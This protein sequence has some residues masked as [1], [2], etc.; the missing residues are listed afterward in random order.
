M[1]ATVEDAKSNIKEIADGAAGDGRRVLTEQKEKLSETFSSTV[2][3][4][5]Q[6]R[7]L[8]QQSHDAFGQRAAE[9]STGLDR[10]SS[11]LRD[12]E[13]S[14]IY[15]DAEHFTRWRSAVLSTCR[16]K[17]VQAMIWL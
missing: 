7:N 17:E 14:E 10:V 12:K 16:C 13:L 4:Q 15:Y 9:I 11:Y 2:R 5:K 3:P 8:Q 1:A 6:L